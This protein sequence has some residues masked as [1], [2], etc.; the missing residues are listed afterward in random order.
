VLS[1]ASDMPPRNGGGCGEALASLPH[2]NPWPSLPEQ[3]LDI[4]RGTS[5]QLRV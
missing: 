3:K 2:L 4:Y 1:V 5:N